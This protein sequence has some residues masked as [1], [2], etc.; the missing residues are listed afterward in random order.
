MLESSN[1][2]CP[3][4]INSSYT[5]PLTKNVA[6]PLW[7]KEQGDLSQLILQPRLME[8]LQEPY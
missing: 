6:Y 7:S 1:S 5:K 2:D 3:K 8:Y 4:H